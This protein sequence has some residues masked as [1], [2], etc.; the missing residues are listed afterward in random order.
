M[1]VLRFKLHCIVAKFLVH[2]IF[3]LAK[4]IL[5]NFETKE[6]MYQRSLRCKMQFPCLIII[7]VALIVVSIWM[8]AISKIRVLISKCFLNYKLRLM[9]ALVVTNDIGYITNNKQIANDN[10]ASRRIQ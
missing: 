7:I 8:D 5:D 3:M 6:M 4:E 10:F 9:T 1:Q 2:L